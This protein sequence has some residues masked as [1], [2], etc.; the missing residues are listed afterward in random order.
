MKK[1]LMSLEKYGK[2]DGKPDCMKCNADP[3]HYYQTLLPK[4]LIMRGPWP[5]VYRGFLIFWDNFD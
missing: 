2:L 3:H 5:L 1:N 4:Q